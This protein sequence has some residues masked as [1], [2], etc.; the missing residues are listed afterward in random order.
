MLML[1]QSVFILLV[2]CTIQQGKLGSEGGINGRVT[3][4]PLA[5]ATAAPKALASSIVVV[6]SPKTTGVVPVITNNPKPDPTTQTATTTTSNNQNSNPQN[7]INYD[8][9]PINSANRLSALTYPIIGLHSATTVYIDNKFCCKY[10]PL[11]SSRLNETCQSPPVLS[12][13]P[14][15]KEKRYSLLKRAIIN[16]FNASTGFDIDQLDFDDNDDYTFDED[17]DSQDFTLTDSDMQTDISEGKK[18]KL[19]ETQEPSKRHCTNQCIAKYM[20]NTIMKYLNHCQYPINECYDAGN[21]TQILSYPNDT[22]YHDINAHNMMF[23]Y[24]GY[25]P[26]IFQYDSSN[27]GEYCEYFKTNVK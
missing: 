9:R 8:P 21:C 22:V 7:N 5:P 18:R 13:K 11:V 14:R 10:K 19:D 1:I 26:S 3:G 15:K 24:Y 27:I 17:L 25:P 2:Q 23:P 4:D 6:E 12:K 20:S 16:S